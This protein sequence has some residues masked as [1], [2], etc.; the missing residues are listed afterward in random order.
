M[1]FL[2]L[3]VV[4]A[5]LILGLAQAVVAAGRRLSAAAKHLILT[6]GIAAFLIVPLVTVVAPA[7]RV[8]VATESAIA[9]VPERPLPEDDAVAAIPPASSPAVRTVSTAPSRGPAIAG[10]L[11]L[12]VAVAILARLARTALRLRTIVSHAS[13]PSARL[14]ALLRD[15][16]P[17]R[18]AVRLLRSDRVKVPMVWGIRSGTLLV[19]AAAEEWPDELLRATFIHEL[20]HLQ[21]LD[22]VS[23][24]F[25]NLVSALLWFHPQVWL[26]RRQAL[27]EGERA[28]DDLVLRAGERASAYASHLLD[29]ARSTPPHEPLGALLAMS[30]PSQLEGRMVA[31]LSP[32]INR[33]AI[34]ERR[35]MISLISFLMLVVPF[36]IVQF[37]AEPAI[38]AQPAVAARS[39]AVAIAPVSS[40]VPAPA[41]ATASATAVVTAAPTETVPAAMAPEGTT[42]TEASSVVDVVEP[43]G[44]TFVE[45]PE[46]GEPV[47][48]ESLVSAMPLV[49]GTAAPASVVPVAAAAPAVA[50]PSAVIILSQ[51]ELAARP[52]RSLGFVHGKTCTMR[53]GR[54]V[55]TGDPAANPAEV[56]ATARLLKQATAKHADAVTKLQCARQIAIGPGCPTAVVCDAEAIAFSGTD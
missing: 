47:P 5:S 1:V 20:G 4:K 12:L 32:S 44:E 22:Y 56:L 19:P 2:A 52:F 17:S 7:W 48:E 3:S 37:A 33:Q 35:L 9:R 15:V 14:G 39:V 36:S 6:C 28:C 41:V 46:L 29:V 27:A 25:M 54:P 21:R 34:G 23:L 8:T 18:L 43:A 50:Q 38:A 53:L 49:E 16:Q 45:E 10:L 24:A 30:R 51:A 11:W 13:A 31:I 26:A 42:A 40:A 55:N